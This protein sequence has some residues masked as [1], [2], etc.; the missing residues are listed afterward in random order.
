YDPRTSLWE[1]VDPKAEKMAG[2]SPYNYGFDNPV[3][4]TDPDGMKPDV[5]PIIS[6]IGGDDNGKGT[7]AQNPGSPNQQPHQPTLSFSTLQK[8]YPLPYTHRPDRTPA[9]GYTSAS[10]NDDGSFM[11]YNQCA[12][13]MSITLKKSGV[14]ISKTK[15]ITNPGGEVFTK[16]GNVMGATNLAGFLKGHLG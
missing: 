5:Q 10:D 6:G 11:Y 15:N 4:F 7:N 1:S 2:W 9:P 3:K 12:I 8:N 14:D 16:D 13:R